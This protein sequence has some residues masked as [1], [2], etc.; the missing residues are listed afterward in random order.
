MAQ[1][2]F[3][4]WDL[5]LT[6]SVSST[7][8]VNYQKIKSEYSGDLKQLSEDWSKVNAGSLNTN[9]EL[10]FWINLYNLST[11]QLIVNHWP[12][13]SI[14]D[15][16]NGNPWEKKW[17]KYN[18][19]LISLNHIEH[20]IIRKKFKDARIHFAVN[21]AAKSC[22]P[23]LNN[24]YVGNKVQ[25]QLESQTKKFINNPKFNTITKNSAEVTQLMNW[26][27][28]DFGDVLS[29]I[30]KYSSTKVDKGTTITF[31]EY[32]WALNN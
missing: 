22:P 1:V 10:A 4:K 19:D 13:K 2:D 20:E 15:I 12:V 23:L 16:E 27:K 30:N 25:N 7:G 31:K 9:D 24:A 18:G 11:V 21:C 6:K 8:K 5:I 26:Y 32:D 17:I 14:K 28:E 3:N 29:Y